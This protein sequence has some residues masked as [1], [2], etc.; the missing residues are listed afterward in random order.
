MADISGADNRVFIDNQ[1][2]SGRI[3]SFIFSDQTLSYTS[4]A[5]LANANNDQSLT[6]TSSSD[7]MNGGA[8]ADTLKA[9]AVGHLPV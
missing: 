4:V 1:G 3:E 6:G 7:T 5:S 9:Q 8:G 2:S